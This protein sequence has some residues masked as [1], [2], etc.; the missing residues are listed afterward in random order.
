MARVCGA[1]G[2]G[3]SDRFCVHMSVMTAGPANLYQVLL[4]GPGWAVA[5]L[6]RYRMA[7][8]ALS[9]PDWR[10]LYDEVVDSVCGQPENLPSMIASWTTLP[11]AVDPEHT[12]LGAW[13]GSAAAACA[14][15]R[16]RAI[17]LGASMDQVVTPLDE[18]AAVAAA[19]IWCAATGINDLGRAV[20]IGIDAV[21][22]L[23]AILA[24]AAGAG[25][26]V[27]TSVDGDPLP[28]FTRPAV[29]AAIVRARAW[30]QDQ[31]GS[32]GAERA[33]DIV[34][35]DLTHGSHRNSLTFQAALRATHLSANRA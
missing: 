35:S 7:D 21:S 2:L 1:P 29:E 6:M 16:L 30:L 34:V 19:E 8:E 5:D 31:L 27:C 22:S 15:L 18:A 28:I 14:P 13:W 3:H 23:A 25:E 9:D 12:L 32:A 4:D 10:S 11:S 33:W 26:L 17:E 20:S 24:R